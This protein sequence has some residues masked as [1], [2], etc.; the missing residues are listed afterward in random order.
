MCVCVR[1]YILIPVPRA[2]LQRY[3]ADDFSDL[4]RAARLRT[5]LLNGTTRLGGNYRLLLTPGNRFAPMRTHLAYGTRT[6]PCI[7]TFQSPSIIIL[8]VPEWAHFGSGSGFEPF[9]SG[10]SFELRWDC[11]LTKF[12]SAPENPVPDLKIT[13]EPVERRTPT[14]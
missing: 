10:Y 5:P 2:S 7:P 8:L 4:A 9:L 14:S 12:L 1:A 6:Q 13:Q 11:P 3:I